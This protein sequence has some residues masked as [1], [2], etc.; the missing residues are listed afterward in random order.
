M[1]GDFGI[2]CIAM[3]AIYLV[4]IIDFLRRGHKKYVLYTLP[5]VVLPLFHL[6][7][8]GIGGLILEKLLKFNP[9]RFMV[10]TV[11]IGIAISA[12]LITVVARLIKKKKSALCYSIIC[13]SYTC[14]I[15]IVLVMNMMG[16]F[17]DF[18]LLS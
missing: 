1:L 5:L 12:M 15:G 8:L 6:I 13:F 3:L 14:I 17:L 18:S 11:L 2:E 4:V 9:Y 7:G 16:N 10:C